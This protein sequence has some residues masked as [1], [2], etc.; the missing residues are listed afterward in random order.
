MDKTLTAFKN[1][2]KD[3]D[4][5]FV[6]KGVLVLGS[7]Y[8][9]YKLLKGLG[10]IKDPNAEKKDIDLNQ[11]IE[12]TNVILSSSLVNDI[13][14]KGLNYQDLDQNLAKKLSNDFWYAWKFGVLDEKFLINIF[15]QLK[16]QS[17]VSILS[18]WVEG[19]YGESLIDHITKHLGSIFS[20]DD[21][22]T[23]IKQIFDRIKKLPSGIIK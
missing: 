23:A 22:E 1:K 9:A 6:V 4:V 17:Q 21:D 15:S 3:I 7:L 19:A 20:T 5:N 2:A 8:S 11:S 14:S 12:D 18:A 13:K 10:L 16:Y